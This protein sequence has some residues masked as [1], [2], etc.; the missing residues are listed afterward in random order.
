MI[1]K[2]SLVL[3][4]IIFS[5]VP[6][7]CASENSEINLSKRVEEAGITL[8]WDPLS[9][10]GILEKN[11]HKIAFQSGNN[12]IVK[13]YLSIEQGTA[14][15]V[16]DGELVATEGFFLSAVNFFTQSSENSFSSSKDLNMYKVGAI[17]I[18][19][20]HGG[21]DAGATA[22]HD[23]NGKKV[24]VYEKDLNLKVALSIY[25][26][27]KK[28]YPEKKIL[29]TRTTDV[30]LDLEK[31]TDIANSVRLSENEAVLYVSIHANASIISSAS[32]FEVWY[33]D[34]NYR[35]DVVDSS[36]SEDKTLLA[37]LNSM[38]EEEYTTES[39]LMAKFI[40]EGM[41]E[42]VGTLTSSRGIKAEKWF[43]VKNAKMPSVLIET[44]FISNKKECALLCDE[45]YLQKLSVGIY[46]GIKS[47][48]IHF[49]RSR[50]FTGSR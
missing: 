44:G 12:F 17:L 16:K 11:G 43:V 45:D 40:T 30:F 48:I 26:L 1:R 8:Y 28:N 41:S 36:V 47:F 4:F 21:R 42:Q 50:G 32:G 20:G 19:A 38:M 15:Y 10:S 46:N 39:I 49:E 14:P 5:K 2:I 18:D 23:F 7:L 34:P 24:T 13:D 29:M 6:L 27:L 33:L 25:E 35:R 9:L 3:I 22:T 37:I 31:R